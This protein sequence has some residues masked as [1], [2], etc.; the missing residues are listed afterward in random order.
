MKI[1]QT[2][3]FDAENNLCGWRKK[4]L[5]WRALK[6]SKPWPIQL[7][8]IFNTNKHELEKDLKKKSTHSTNIYVKCNQDNISN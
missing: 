8:C 7:T 2:N 6:N 4:K 1:E 3:K 5:C